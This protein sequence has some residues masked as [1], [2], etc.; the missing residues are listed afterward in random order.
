MTSL[1]CG[2]SQATDILWPER[3]VSIIHHFINAIS[4]HI[5]RIAIHVIYQTRETVIF[6]NLQTPK[7]ELYDAIFSQPLIILGYI[8]S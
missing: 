1:S 6:I 8:Q 7:R 3:T 2:H 4:A 5:G